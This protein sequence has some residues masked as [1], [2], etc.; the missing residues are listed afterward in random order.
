MV[1]GT[2]HNVSF[3]SFQSLLGLLIGDVSD[4]DV[5]WS[6]Y[7]DYFLISMIKHLKICWT[8]VVEFILFECCKID[9]SWITHFNKIMNWSGLDTGQFLSLNSLEF[10]VSLSTCFCLKLLPWSSSVLKVD[11]IQYQS[12]MDTIRTKIHAV[13][14][15]GLLRT[16]EI[17][18]ITRWQAEWWPS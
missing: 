7:I 15:E 12:E 3:S 18:S 16:R 14:N 10:L 6:R 13:D 8:F 4:N 5:R 17:K 11:G 2:S 9:S 1:L